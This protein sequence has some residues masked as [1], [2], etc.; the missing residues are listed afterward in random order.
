MTATS[1]CCVCDNFKVDSNFRVGANQEVC[2]KVPVDVLLKLV[3]FVL[4]LGM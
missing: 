4:L 1:K 2:D 3:K